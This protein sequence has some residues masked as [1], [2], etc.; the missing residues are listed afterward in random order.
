V[1]ED[2][3]CA[4]CHLEEA[5]AHAGSRHR[6]AFSNGAFQAAYRLEPTAFCRGC[7]APEADPREAP[8]AGEGAIGVGC[9]T[10]HV[11]DEGV[12]LAAPG[13]ATPRDQA[14]PGDRPG[15]A[16]HA[17]ARREDFAGP[18]ACVSCH[19][20]RF[21]GTAGAGDDAFMQTTGREHARS[22][23]SERPC[24]SC[25]MPERAG[26]RAHGF[27]EVRDPEWLRGALEA[28]A[29]ATADG[30]SVRL[31]QT[32][33]GHAFPTGDLFRRLEVGAERRDGRGRVVARAVRHLARRFEVL[34][35]VRGRQLAADD[36]VFDE[37][38]AVDLELPPGPVGSRLVWW[39]SLQ[40]V[41]QAFDGQRPERATLESE[42]LLHRG[43]IEGGN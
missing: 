19:E 33:P 28:R 24:A 11:V 34:P 10:C 42:V 32:M 2:R 26:R 27:G 31:R 25:H 29:S 14:E 35:G 38:M 6:A 36:R 8:A 22:A 41:A 39:V 4:S 9:V 20:F 12:V 23:S 30:V 18:G 7:H 40:R 21:P 5:R 37:P 16:P 15:E 13:R 17:I 3:R 43:T 1:E